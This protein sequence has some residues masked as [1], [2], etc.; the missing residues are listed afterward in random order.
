[1]KAPKEFK[2]KIYVYWNTKCDFFHFSDYPP[3]I[4]CDTGERIALSSVEVELEF[5]DS[6]AAQV[7]AL[8][9]QI[10]KQRAE[11]MHR[12]DILERKKSELLALEVDG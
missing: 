6:T 7:A 12:I 4:V 9:K 2:G 8:E 5:P 3:E 10:E 11:M 1:M